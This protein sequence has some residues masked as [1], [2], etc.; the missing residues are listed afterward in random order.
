MK[1]VNAVVSLFVA[2]IAAILTK[3]YMPEKNG[4]GLVIDFIQLY[5]SVAEEEILRRS[6]EEVPGVDNSENVEDMDTSSWEYGG[7]AQELGAGQEVVKSRAVLKQVKE[8]MLGLDDDELK[9]NCVNQHKSCVFW[10]SLGECSAN[11]SYM[12]VSCAPACLTCP[13]IRFEHR[14]PIPDNLAETAIFKPHNLNAM[15]GRVMESEEFRKYKP[16]LV[17]EGPYIL[18]FDEFLTDE[19]C[20]ALV[21]FGFDKGF[22]RS[23]DVGKTQFSGES[24]KVISSHRTSSNAWCNKTCEEDPVINRIHEKIAEVTGVPFNNSEHLQI[25]QYFPGQEYKKHHDFIQGDSDKKACGPRVLTLLLYLNDVEEGG[26]TS[27]PDLLGGGIVVTPKKGKA[28][29]WPSVLDGDPTRRDA[30]TMHQ[31]NPVVKG[32]KYA[33]NSWLHL[34]DFKTPN[35]AGCTG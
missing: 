5:S 7:L 19:E 4:F 21:E 13:K 34:Y 1:I 31:A 22:E 3:V 10:A 30:R 35:A 8:H 17:K 2:I 28:L 26:G 6:T 20:D 14:C 25:L 18:T 32:V 11:P 24:E 29:M 15:F 9:Q 16:V 33:A 27:F 23:S 12:H